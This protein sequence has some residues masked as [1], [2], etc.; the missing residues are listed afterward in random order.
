M[1]VLSLFDG[2]SAG[3]VAF[4]RSGIPIEKYYASEID[5]Y[6]IKITQKNYPNTIQLGSILYS[7]TW[8]I[9]HPDIII[10]GFPCQP[11]SNAG[12]RKGLGDKRGGDILDAMFS[13]IEKYQPKDL[14]FENVKG[15]LSIDNG[16]TFKF[17]LKKFNYLGYAVDWIII[18]SALVSAQNRERIYIICKKITDC[19][20]YQ[21]SIDKDNKRNYFQSLFESENNIIVFDSEVTQ[22]KDKKI[23]LQD[24]IETGVTDRTKSYCLDANYAKGGNEKSYLEQGKRQLIIT[25]GAFRGRNPEHPSDRTSGIDTEQC[26]EVNET[27]KSNC[28]TKDSLCVQIGVADI[29]GNDNIK[30]VYSV[31][32]KSPCLTAICGGNQEPKISEEKIT[33]RKLTP[34]ECE[35]L[36]TLKDNYTDCVSN[37]RR[38]HSV[39]NSWTVDVISHI[40][41]IILKEVKK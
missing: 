25:G 36:Q 24:I 7:Q 11:Y 30:R 28:L 1:K 15:L 14:F 34:V 40:F 5:P 21:I 9:E 29:K 33:W 10:G 16:N 38:Y 19:K 31:E 26:L 4:E 22:P 23:F 35:R 27:G 32:G 39:G 6:A 13:V 17:I 3:Q 12:K 8:D 37:S 20:N 41:S 2:I 18:N